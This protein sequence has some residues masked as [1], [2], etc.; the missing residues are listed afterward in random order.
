MDISIG[1]YRS[2]IQIRRERPRAIVEAQPLLDMIDQ[3]VPIGSR[4]WRRQ[5]QRMVPA[6]IGTGNSPRSEPA[7]TVCLQPFEAQCAIQVLT[8]ICLNFHFLHVPH[9][10]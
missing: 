8:D 6:R 5:Q 3:Y 7:A 2:W 10:S 9:R 1:M 4:L